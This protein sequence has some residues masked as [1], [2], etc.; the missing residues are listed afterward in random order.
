MAKPKQ[1]EFSAEETERRARDAIRRSFKM[2]Y[3]PHK[4][5]IGKTPRARAMAQRKAKAAQESK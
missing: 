2:P 5:L 4:E 1:D 3:K